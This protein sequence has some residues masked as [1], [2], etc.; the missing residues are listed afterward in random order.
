LL[1][2]GRGDTGARCEATSA[3]MAMANS[4]TLLR[5]TACWAVHAYTAS[6]ALAALAAMLEV[7]RGGVR[8]AFLW[9]SIAVAVDATDGF[10]ARAARV[11]DFLPHYDGA[12]LDDIV[13]FLTFVVVP[14]FL[15]IETGYLAGASGITVACFAVLA[16]AFRFCHADAKTPDHFFT[17]FPS[18]W[19]VLAL[20]LY[21][22]DASQGASRLITLGLA[23]AVFAP[24]R[25]IYPSRTVALRTWTIALGVVWAVIVIAVVLALPERARTLA[26]VSLA[27]PLY[28]TVVSLALQFGGSLQR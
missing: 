8:A 25:F 5:R 26:A 23:L 3:V 11:K 21:V 1:A 7:T 19:N 20:Y 27:Y 17:G 22:F 4:P 14:L 6:G 18:Y 13:D 10:L 12:E 24:L 16:S 9:L 28:Y 2:A 15:L